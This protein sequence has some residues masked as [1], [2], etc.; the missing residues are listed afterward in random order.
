MSRMG[1]D[2]VNPSGGTYAV[3]L[4]HAVKKY[5]Q[6]KRYGLPCQFHSWWGNCSTSS[7][8]SRAPD[9]CLC[10]A[11]TQGCPMATQHRRSGAFNYKRTTKA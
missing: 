9:L 3:G 2:L 6:D 1:R 5:W 7:L 4:R 11:S 8:R 10:T